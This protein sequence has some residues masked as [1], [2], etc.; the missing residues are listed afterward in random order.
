M[1]SCCRIVACLLCISANSIFAPI[2]SY[3]VF[4]PPN[5]HDCLVIPCDTVWRNTRQPAKHV[6]LAS[7]PQT[8][9]P[10]SKHVD[11]LQSLNALIY[12]IQ[13]ISVQIDELLNNVSKN[14]LKIVVTCNKVCLSDFP[15][16]ES[17]QNAIVLVG[18]AFDLNN[19]LCKQCRSLL[20]QC[21]CKN[22]ERCCQHC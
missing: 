10:V 7:Q 9:V 20:V 12:R 15:G 13:T 2:F 5:K 14:G 8:V 18:R 16:L 1:V 21:V 17:T 4:L 6:I 22:S 11:Q 3:M 19:V